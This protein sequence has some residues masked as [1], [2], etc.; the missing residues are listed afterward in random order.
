MAS[1]ELTL[2]LPIISIKKAGQDFQLILSNSQVVNATTDGKFKHIKMPTLQGLNN[3][4]LS[5]YGLKT[6][7]KQTN[8][9]RILIGVDMA[10]N[11]HG[12]D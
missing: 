9:L 4:T 1:V 5:N 11:K 2:N 3:C 6:I 10:M 12:G 7:I 8:G